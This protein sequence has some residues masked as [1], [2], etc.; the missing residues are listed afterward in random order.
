MNACR[1]QFAHRASISKVEGMECRNLLDRR[2][3]QPGE[4]RVSGNSRNVG[5]RVFKRKHVKGNKLRE[6]Y[7]CTSVRT[8][9]DFRFVPIGR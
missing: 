9:R 8:G 1:R 5:L 3:N 6:V 4:P 2:I 7:R